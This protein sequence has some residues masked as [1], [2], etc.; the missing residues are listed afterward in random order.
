MAM[1][2]A[3]DGEEKEEERDKDS[4]MDAGSD[5]RKGGGHGRKR[6][7][8]DSERKEVAKRRKRWAKDDYETLTFESLHKGSRNGV[9]LYDDHRLPFLQVIFY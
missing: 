8:S 6:A 1:A 9:R 7:A 4:A 2:T 3:I 5:S